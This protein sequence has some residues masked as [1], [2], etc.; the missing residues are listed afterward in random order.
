M[1]TISDAKY[2]YPITRYRM[3]FSFI[4]SKHLYTFFFFLLLLIELMQY[5]SFLVDPFL[6]LFQDPLWNA[7]ATFF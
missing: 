2:Y 7:C 6:R 4:T 3:I 1:I 5:L